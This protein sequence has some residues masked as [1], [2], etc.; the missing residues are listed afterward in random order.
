MFV[1]HKAS[2]SQAALDT[3]PDLS[4]HR[5]KT[6]RESGRA[7]H[8]DHGDVDGDGDIDLLVSGDGDS[9]VFLLL[10]EDD[11]TFTTWVFDEEMPQAGSINIGDLNGDSI[12][13]LIVSSFDNNGLY[14]YT[15]TPRGHTHCV[16]DVP[17]WAGSQGGSLRINHDGDAT[18][19]LVVGLF[20]TW[21]PMG[22]PAG[23]QLFDDPIYPVVAE[24]PAVAP[25]DYVAL[26][27]IDVD[28]SGIMGPNEGDVET[29]VDVTLP[30]ASPVDVYL[31]GNGA[32]AWSDAHASAERTKRCANRIH[33]KRDGSVGC[34]HV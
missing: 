32:A 11:Q 12:P 22:P 8:F 24:F 34:R 5:I 16:A 2:R 13:E 21:P 18:G 20:E 31:D 33:G 23:F 3:R 17:D 28:G 14:M 15:Q 25:G 30:T 7:R 29:T 1:V 6:A 9:R 19:K 26:A 10:Q 27:F 4:K